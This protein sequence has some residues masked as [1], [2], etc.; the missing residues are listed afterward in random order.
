MGAGKLAAR[1]IDCY[2][3]GVPMVPEVEQVD[4]TEIV[5]GTE[6]EPRPKPQDQVH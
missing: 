6:A 4:D 5:A 1:S 2:L 3:R